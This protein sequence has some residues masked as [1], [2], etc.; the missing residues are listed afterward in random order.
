[1][2]PPSKKKPPPP[3]PVLAAATM[4]LTHLHSVAQAVAI[5][6][7][8]AVW[9]QIMTMA[10]AVLNDVHVAFSRYNLPYAKAPRYLCNAVS[11]A[12]DTLRKYRSVTLRTRARM[13]RLSKL[14]CRTCGGDAWSQGTG[15]GLSAPSLRPRAPVSAPIP[16]SATQPAPSPVP[17]P[18]PTPAPAAPTKTAVSS[19]AAAPAAQD[20]PKKAPASAPPSAAVGVADAV[21]LPPAPT[22]IAAPPD[23][24]LDFLQAVLSG[25]KLTPTGKVFFAGGK[26]TYT[27]SETGEQKP[28]VRS[29]IAKVIRYINDTAQSTS[30]PAQAVAAKW[31]N[32]TDQKRG[33]FVLHKNYGRA[34]AGKLNMKRLPRIAVPQ[35]GVDLAATNIKK[36][37]PTA[38]AAQRRRTTI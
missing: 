11:C 5:V 1:M 34:A 22:T 33:E 12:L 26:P 15:I 9:G 35:Q 3:P 31:L 10:D 30:A 17:T 14:L 37:Q 29:R 27:K 36:R 18:T 23:F 25:I 24:D 8:S 16:V 4:V 13:A 6:Q 19:A 21:A 38:A 28:M 20:P 32:D 7:T 2:P